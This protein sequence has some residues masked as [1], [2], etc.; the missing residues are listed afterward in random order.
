M[1]DTTEFEN[2]SFSAGP[3]WACLRAGTGRPLLLIHG[4]LCDA[5]FWRGQ[6]PALAAAG[7]AALAPSL[8]AYHPLHLSQ[9]MSWQQ[10][11]DDL[12]ALLEQAGG[13]ERFDVIG[14]SRGGFLAFHLA[15]RAPHL[16]HR[17]VLAEPGGYMASHDLRDVKGALPDQA[18][19]EDVIA[20]VERG[21]SAQ[22]VA[23]FV[24]SVSRP[25]SWRFSPADFRQMALDNASTLISQLRDDALPPYQ[26]S[27]IAELNLPVLLLK[28]QRSLPRF[29]QTVDAL[30]EQLSH[31]QVA[32]VAG[33][34]H[35]MNLA[36]PAKFNQLVIDF[37]QQP[38]SQG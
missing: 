27:E 17:L 18:W 36:Y 2:L 24:D 9:H 1:S 4:S 25:G 7:F 13:G 38:A 35:A 6:L 23:L 29:R 34:S 15:R 10:D 31:A 19:R 30:G 16:L 33:A 14:H 28:G 11:L 8:R 26:P 22:A 21:D 20:M 37:L 32:E 3:L 5:R 12:V